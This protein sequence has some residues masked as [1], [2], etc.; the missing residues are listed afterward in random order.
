MVKIRYLVSILQIILLVSC[1]TRSPMDA[2][3]T[4]TR[5][6][7][8]IDTVTFTVPSTVT[9]TQTTHPTKTSTFTPIATWTPL[10]RLSPYEVNEKI[11]ELLETNGNCELPC[12]WGITPGKTVMAEALHFLEPIVFDLNKIGPVVINKNGR[13]HIYNYVKFNYLLPDHKSSV[14]IDLT[15]ED[16][17]VHGITVYPFGVDYRFQIHQVLRALGVPKQIFIGAQQSAPIEVLPP[18]TLLLDYSDKGVWASYGYIPTKV[19]ENLVICPK[20]YYE[21]VSIYDN[22]GGKLLLF[23]SESE[24]SFTIE[25]YAEPF[26]GFPPRRI[27]D[28]T[29]MDVEGF[30]NT[31]INPNPEVC[32]ETPSSLWP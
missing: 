1:I 23:Y 14:Q 22:V 17:I 26:S 31:F 13:K 27:E 2:N 29:N 18:T 10:P 3:I 11:K 7:Q 28:V 5:E 4:E 15:A 16:D 12:Y 25:E 24:L 6:P 9:S 32:L 20:P 30:Y 8:V 19:G 21:K